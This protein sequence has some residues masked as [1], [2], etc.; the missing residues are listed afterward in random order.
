MAPR[1]LILDVDTG[2][3]DAVAIMLA[4]LHPD[5]E[6][7]AC[8]TVNGNREI[9]H[10]TENTLRTLDHI[11]RG[12]IPVHAGLAR[13]IAR[14]DFPIPRAQ[15]DPGVHFVEMPLAKATSK[16]QAT[17]AVDFLIDFY[18]NT[19]DAVTLVP[20][21]PLSNIAT[22]LSLFPKLVDYIPEVIIM[23][24]GHAIGNVT[25]SAEFNIWADPEAAAM[26]FAAGFPNLTLVPLDATHKAVISLDQCKTLRASG[27]PAAEAAAIFV[28]KR[29]EGYRNYQRLDN[30]DAAPIHDALCIAAMI[31]P[32]V[33]TT[34]DYFVDVETEGRLTVGRTVLD[35]NK[36]AKR[37]PN[38]HVA[39]TA[40]TA[41]FGN[42]VLDT[43]INN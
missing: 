33:I 5:L 7:V 10:T 40:N 27:K 29:V 38:A 11:G 25:S 41:L 13:P 43:L 15:R 30:P 20:V 18:R 37:D 34:E 2:T 8:T 21:G 16:V 3:D 28:E 39:M 14:L 31:Y 32:E 1:K 19:T 12:D 42:F 6:L 4:A 24:G 23:G 17:N 35:V 22:A 26:V 36:R 9:E